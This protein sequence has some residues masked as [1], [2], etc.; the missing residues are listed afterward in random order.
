MNTFLDSG[1]ALA[2]SAMLAPGAA[3]YTSLGYRVLTR[4]RYAKT[5]RNWLIV[6]TVI[7]VFLVNRTAPG[8]PTQTLLVAGGVTA[9]VLITGK[10]PRFL[11]SFIRSLNIV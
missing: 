2:Q 7:A 1:A 4:S 6:A 8:L 10:G 3:L 11:R 9:A 5:V